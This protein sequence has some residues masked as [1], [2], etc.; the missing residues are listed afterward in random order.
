MLQAGIAS[1][2]VNFTKLKMKVFQI[3]K[4]PVFEKKTGRFEFL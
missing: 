1:R 4:R 2:R 3:K